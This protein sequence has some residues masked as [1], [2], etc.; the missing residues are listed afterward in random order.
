MIHMKVKKIIYLHFKF[1]KLFS[2][3]FIVI[4]NVF[5]SKDP[6]ARDG[7]TS[8]QPNRENSDIGRCDAGYPGSLPKVMGTNGGEFFPGFIA[9][10][11]NGMVVE[12]IRDSLPGD[13][14]R[15]GNLPLFA[16]NITFIFQRN[17]TCTITSGERSRA[18]NGPLVA[19][20]N[21]GAEQLSLG[22][23]FLTS[24]FQTV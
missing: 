8:L 18:A 9:Q 21:W 11:L 20:Y 23:A 5:S 19:H 3:Y 14:F 1:I 15:S 2:I 6:S 4:N 22:G 24:A 7:S 12:I 10:G 16:I 17:S 13:L